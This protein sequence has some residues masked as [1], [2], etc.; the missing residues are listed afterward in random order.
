M[1]DI[2]AYFLKK[3]HN[4]KGT[5]LQIYDSFYDPERG[6]TAHKAY[7]VIGYVHESEAK[8]IE[9]PISYYKEEI[10]KL[11]LMRKKEKEKV[12]EISEDTP[13]RL[14]AFFL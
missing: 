12:K 3:T 7:K 11:N 14:L 10:D 2:M 9:D 4:K 1:S 5:Y 6:H 8:G 13:E